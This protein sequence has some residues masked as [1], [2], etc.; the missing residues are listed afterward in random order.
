VI[1]S[2]VICGIAQLGLDHQAFL[3]PRLEDIAA[4]KAGIAKAGVPLVTQLYP[5]RIG[6]RIGEI[7]AAAGATWLPRG[8]K[9]DAA[10]YQQKL[11]YRDEAGKFDLP[12]PRLRGAHQ[13]G[14]AGLAIAMLRHQ[15]AIDIGEPAIRAAMGWT[16][17][18]ARLQK[19]GAGP[20]QALLPAGSELWLDGGHN[21]AAARAVADFF[22]GYVPAGRPFHIV[23]GLLENK[24][25]PG[26]LKP[27]RNR[28]I[29][30]HSIPV[31]GHAHHSPSDLAGAAREAG[32]NA[33]PAANLDEALRWIGRHA[34]R[35]QPPIVL[36]LGSLYLAGEVLRAN[37][38]VPV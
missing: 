24:D 7:A 13:A 25:A 23:F 29:T 12:L 15:K 9:W 31:E 34:D 14:N 18:P 16:E 11:H 35:A 38:Q 5:D 21:P 17:W 30:L 27:F 33:V 6:N 2:P 22:R 3:G 1:P 10:V 36:I 26:V 32:L 37:A 8:G 28:A 19:L 20:L 4:E